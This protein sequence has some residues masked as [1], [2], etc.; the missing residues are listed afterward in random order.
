LFGTL[1]AKADFFIIQAVVPDELGAYPSFL[2]MRKNDSLVALPMQYKFWRNWRG[3]R[4][5][6]EFVRAVPFYGSEPN[7]RVEPVQVVQY[8]IDDEKNLL[9][10][11]FI[12]N[13]IEDASFKPDMTNSTYLLAVSEKFD[14]QFKR[15][16]IF[17]MQISIDFPAFLV[18]H[19][20]KL[21][22]ERKNADRFS[23]IK[24]LRADAIDGGVFGNVAASRVVTLVQSGVHGFI[25]SPV[26]F[27]Q[28]ELTL[29]LYCIT[30]NFR[31]RWDLRN[32][33]VNRYNSNPVKMTFM[34]PT[35]GGKKNTSR[36]EELEFATNSVA[37]GLVRGKRIPT[38]GDDLLNIVVNKK[39]FLTA[40]SQ[41]S[42]Q[43]VWYSSGGYGNTNS[44]GWASMSGNHNALKVN[45][46]TRPLQSGKE[47]TVFSCQTHVVFLPAYSGFR[48]SCG[49]FKSPLM[50]FFG[51][52]APGFG[53]TSMFK[54]D[55]DDLMH[56]WPEEGN[57]AYFI[58]VDKNNNGKIDDYRE[59]FATDPNSNAFEKLAEYDTNKDGLITS[60]DSTWKVLTLWNDKNANSEVDS[61]EI[62]TMDELGVKSISV[63]YDNVDVT[64]GP[65]AKADTVSEFKYEKDG[66][67]LKGE[68]YDVYFKAK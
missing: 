34:M 43:L 35:K 49:G 36:T 18:A 10:H 8:F 68:C 44:W 31:S 7:Y 61:G 26:P 41:Q 5:I 32:Y 25:P 19:N 51:E 13:E 3:H 57:D 6:E 66:K 59:I 9:R 38:K 22:L 27:V 58:V 15:K 29:D 65:L 2:A 21:E 54:L 67:I 11:I 45:C 28:G 12:P 55:E 16:S 30:H 40:A 52:R 23:F 53:A 46:Q 50:L 4:R 60:D 56:S 37:N 17:S 62:R 14:L 42:T 47:D 64:F 39:V 33:G 24:E 1:W 20:K 63:E 48:G